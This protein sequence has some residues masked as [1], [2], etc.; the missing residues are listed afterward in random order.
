MR[1]TL[2]VELLTEELPPKAL[3]SLGTTFTRALHEGLKEAAFI[4][5][6]APGPQYILAT[7]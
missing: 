2:L 3:L 7:P 6:D 5:A 4:A 1:D